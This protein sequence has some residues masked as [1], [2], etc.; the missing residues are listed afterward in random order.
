MVWLR[1]CYL[2]DIC[3]VLF[4]IDLQAH[5]INSFIQKIQ[6]AHVLLPSLHKVRAGRRVILIHGY[7]CFYTLNFPSKDISSFLY[8]MSYRCK[9]VQ[10]YTCNHLHF[11]FIGSIWLW[12]L[13]YMNDGSRCVECFLLVSLCLHSAREGSDTIDASCNFAVKLRGRVYQNLKSFLYDKRL[14]Y[15]ENRAKT[16]A[17][18]FVTF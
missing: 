4:D 13:S 1:Y 3:W 7:L 10:K 17:F 12:P 16:Y 18:F 6:L 5:W 2:L 14:I 8:G 9:M 11:H 15:D